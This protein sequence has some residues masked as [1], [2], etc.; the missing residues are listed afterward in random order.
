MEKLALFDSV[1]AGVYVHNCLVR[2]CGCPT[3]T[4]FIDVLFRICAM[5]WCD[6]VQVREMTGSYALDPRGKVV[7]LYS[8]YTAAEIETGTR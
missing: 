3:G 5:V 2:C 4:D 8:Q 1:R 6:V 7:F